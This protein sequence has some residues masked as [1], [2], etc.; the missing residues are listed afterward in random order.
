MSAVDAGLRH[1]LEMA[2]QRVDALNRK[3]STSQ[4]NALEKKKDTA[5]IVAR[6]DGITPRKHHGVGK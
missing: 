6:G 2:E 4:V 3:P 5:Q 1:R